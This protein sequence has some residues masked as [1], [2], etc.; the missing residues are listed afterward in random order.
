MASQERIFLNSLTMPGSKDVALDA[1]RIRELMDWT[2]SFSE[3][4]I[5]A[6]SS[7]CAFNNN[8]GKGDPE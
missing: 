8:I 6:I 5:I 7:S 4:D 3:E 1:E 2:I